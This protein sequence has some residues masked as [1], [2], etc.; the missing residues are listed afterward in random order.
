[1]LAPA[2]QLEDLEARDGKGKWGSA[3]NA[4]GDE[5]VARTETEG[6]GWSGKVGETPSGSVTGK[7]GRWR[8]MKVTGKEERENFEADGLEA[9]KQMEALRVEWEARL[10]GVGQEVSEDL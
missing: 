3:I 1:V 5:R 7:L 4:A 2:A 8:N 9:W 6:W 10:G